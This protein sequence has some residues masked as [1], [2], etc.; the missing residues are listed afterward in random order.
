[1]IKE[2]SLAVIG[3]FVTWLIFRLSQF[4][5]R[6]SLLKSLKFELKII[7]R[8]LSGS[9]TND[10]TNREW[11]Y[12]LHM[13]IGLRK[14]IVTPSIL[15][16]D[17]TLLFSDEL[18]ENLGFLNAGIE[19]FQQHLERYLSFITANPLLTARAC[20][21]LDEIGFDL[22]VEE[23]FIKS[24]VEQGLSGKG[25]LSKRVS[26]FIDRV[27]GLNK[28]LHFDGIANDSYYPDKVNGRKF[29]KPHMSYILALKSCENEERKPLCFFPKFYIF[30]DVAMLLFLGF[31]LGGLFS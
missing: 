26:V 20:K 7:G 30:V 21:E 23:K 16:S 27:Y 1:M 17:K 5:T 2:L 31:A 9:Y 11:Y 4:N 15:A 25:V 19:R 10:S 14:S 22:G 24:L 29:P 12:P 18:I 8:W 13:V 3:A 6:N 28:E